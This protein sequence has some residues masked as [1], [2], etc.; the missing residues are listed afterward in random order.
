MDIYLDKTNNI[1][2]NNFRVI[3]NP[4]IILIQIEP[5]PKSPAMGFLFFAKLYYNYRRGDL[6]IYDWFGIVKAP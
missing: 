4:W 1:S 6:T 2:Y 5:Q 3:I